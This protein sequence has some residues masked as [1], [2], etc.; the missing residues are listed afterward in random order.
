MRLLFSYGVWTSHR[1]S[2]SCGT[3]ALRCAGSGIVHGDLV[4]Q[5]H[6]GFPWTGGQTG[7]SYIARQIL[8][9][10]AIREIPVVLSIIYDSSPLTLVILYYFLLLLLFI[11][12]SS[13]IFKLL[14]P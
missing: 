3:Q 7:V 14:F 9:H 6:V 2:F 1:S 10:W 11:V 12:V 4:A 5:Q 13:F 8:N